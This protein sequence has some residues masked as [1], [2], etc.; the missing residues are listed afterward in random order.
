MLQVDDGSIKIPAT[1]AAKYLSRHGITAMVQIEDGRG[2]KV[3]DVVRTVLA[4]RSASYLVM[5]GFDHPRWVQSM[6]GGVTSTMIDRSP[7]PMLLAH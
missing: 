3:T 2:R 1:E 7:V 6:F 5:G 4:S